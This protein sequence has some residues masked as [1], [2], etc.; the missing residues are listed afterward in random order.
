MSNSSLASAYAALTDPD[1][2]LEDVLDEVI[3]ENE[4]TSVM[5]YVSSEVLHHAGGVG[6][7]THWRSARR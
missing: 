1:S 5:E 3:E 4:L 2:N 7:Q 6:A